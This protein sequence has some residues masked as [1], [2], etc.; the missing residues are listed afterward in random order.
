MAHEVN[1]QI[2]VGNGDGA[3]TERNLQNNANYDNDGNNRGMQMP[4]K[5]KLLSQDDRSAWED[6]R[7]VVF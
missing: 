1:Y 7:N 4:V 3:A 5:A 2:S 6:L